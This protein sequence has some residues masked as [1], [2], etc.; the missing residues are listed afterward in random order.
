MTTSLSRLL[1]PGREPTYDTTEHAY[2]VWPLRTEWARRD[3]IRRYVRSHPRDPLVI[4]AK[5]LHAALS[6]GAK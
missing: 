6:G 2:D 4:A 1:N 5:R 3:A